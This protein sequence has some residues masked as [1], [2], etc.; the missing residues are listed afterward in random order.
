MQVSDEG[1]IINLLKYGENSIVVTVLSLFYV[2]GYVGEIAVVFAVVETVA[3]HE[4]VG[5]REQ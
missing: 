1:Y 4:E 2:F 5:Y 3:Y